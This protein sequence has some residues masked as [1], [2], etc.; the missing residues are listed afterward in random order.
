VLRIESGGALFSLPSPRSDS[1][2][3]LASPAVETT[4]REVP[5]DSLSQAE[6][7]ELS[8]PWV[9]ALAS[10]MGEPPSEP[11]RLAAFHEAAV[12]QLIDRRLKEDRAVSSR[13]EARIQA[14]EKL[15]GAAIRRLAISR[16]GA[17]DSVAPIDDSS[18]IP[19]AR[20]CQAA[21]Q[22]LGL[23]VRIPRSVVQGI[24]RN[25]LQTIARASSLRTRSLVLLDEWWTHDSGPMVALLEAD[26]QPVALLPR[27]G[28]GYE[29]FDPVREST[30][31]VN[32]KTAGVLSGAAWMFYRPFPTR[33]L[34]GLDILFYSLR[35][36]GREVRTLVL[37]ALAAS[38][39]ALVTPFA[40]GIV[41]DSIIPSSDR[42]QLTQTVVLIA[43]ASITAALISLTRGYALLRL[44]GKMDFATQAAVWDRLLNLPAAFFRDYSAGDLANRSMAI[45]QIRAGLTGDT[46]TSVLAGIFSLTNVFLLFY[47][48]PAMAMT[49]IG[50][51]CIAFLATIAAGTAQY[52][53]QRRLAD[54]AGKISGMVFEFI[55]GVAKFRVSGTEGR[56][57]ARWA[58]AFGA[59]RQ[60]SASIR[61]VANTLSVFNTCFPVFALC[62]V[63]TGF[64]GRIGQG[65]GGLSTGTFLA[66]NAAFAQLTASLLAL[67]LGAVT[68][69][70]TIPLYN[71]I[72]P[73]FEAQPEAGEDRADPGEIS[74][75]IEGSH[76]SFRYSSDTLMVLREVSFSIR[77]GEFVAFVGPSGSGK[78]TLFR[79]LLG[80]EKP[81]SG[82]VYYDGQDLSGL[83]PQAVREQVG[84]VLQNGE[85]LPGDI[86]TNIIGSAP[87]TVDQAWEAARIAGM[88][89][90]IKAF[91]MGMYT[92][93]AEGGRGLSGGQRQR[94][95][96]ARAVVRKPKIVLFDEATS[97]LDNR[98][99]DIVT[100]ALDEMRVT[101]IVIAH[102]L[103]TI[104]KAD[105]IYVLDHG[106]IV[107]SGTFEELTAKEG[108]FSDLARRQ[109]A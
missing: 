14:D 79:M 70:K 61:R 5:L 20:A 18:N 56:A 84:V 4:V 76:L 72:R 52:R 77:P 71:R 96:I 8:S 11:I 16:A 80:F 95:M 57:F 87:L 73:I 81:A 32:R 15:V 33:P 91:P 3:F 43:A 25:P 105:R 38:L 66:F 94:L 19:I 54:T 47:Y 93:V 30:V 34:T 50:L 63:F 44:E 107:Q 24:A 101:R 98:T 103:S 83:D 82:A 10:A 1:F 37:S 108:L 68:V 65:Q 48:S 100:S 58:A 23:E 36:A 42:G 41:F 49:A 2:G 106:A 88:E 78:S 60:I 6:I 59:Q 22:A 69:L 85:L 86:L 35:G 109:V 31:R 27:K 28:G 26:Q 40:I 62:V 9:S 17:A 104:M 21:A 97:A 12:Q 45:G 13:L 75:A 102:R 67:G 39:L 74:G 89:E 90:D 51:A 99:Q 64:A 53:L 7:D 29:L 92:V 46:L 55:R